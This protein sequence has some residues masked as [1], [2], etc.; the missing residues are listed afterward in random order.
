MLVSI[1]IAACMCSLVIGLLLGR[2]LHT[3]HINTLKAQAIGKY[4]E[5]QKQHTVVEIYTP[6]V[7]FMP[8][9]QISD[10]NWKVEDCMGIEIV[11]HK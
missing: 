2:M 4:L 9:E 11:S 3:E 1:T 8:V 10:D 5:F 6:N 7:A